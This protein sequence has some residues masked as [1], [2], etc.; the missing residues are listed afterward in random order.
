[1]TYDRRKV[2]V[3]G[4]AELRRR[5]G[6]TSLWAPWGLFFIH[7]THESGI[8]NYKGMNLGWMNLGWISFL[9]FFS[10]KMD[11]IQSVFFHKAKEWNFIT[12]QNEYKACFWSVCRVWISDKGW[13]NFEVCFL[14]I[15]R[16]WISNKEWMNFEV[17]F[18]YVYRLWISDKGWMNFKLC[19][20][21]VYRVWISNKGWMNFKLCFWS[22]HGGKN[23]WWKMDDL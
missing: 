3:G 7:L 21:Y 23:I 8:S 18:L 11:D 12:L 19:F 10:I 2:G 1:M 15:Y 9:L 13:M 17:C 6:G 4:V 5:W 14:S 22:V 20:L 16:V